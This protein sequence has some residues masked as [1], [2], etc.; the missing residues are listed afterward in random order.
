MTKR[1]DSNLKK[2]IG[3]DDLLRLLDPNETE[4]RNALAAAVMEAIPYSIWYQGRSTGP[5][6]AALFV[7]RDLVNSLLEADRDIHEPFLKDQSLDTMQRMSGYERQASLAEMFA[8][9]DRQFPTL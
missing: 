2:S 5:E 7:L 4:L 1:T 9:I 3:S 6:K 8:E